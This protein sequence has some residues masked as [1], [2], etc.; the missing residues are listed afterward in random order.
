MQVIGTGEFGV[1]WR[2]GEEGVEEDDGEGGGGGVDG[3]GEPT[4]IQTKEEIG[5]NE[6]ITMA[7]LTIDI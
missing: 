7:Q 3:E 2:D 1:Y 5:K 4:V 6:V